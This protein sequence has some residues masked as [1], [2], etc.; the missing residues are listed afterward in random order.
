MAGAG[1]LQ[2]LRQMRFEALLDRHERGALSQVEAAEMQGITERTFRR[3]RD[4]RV[5]NTRCRL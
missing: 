4:R 3:W 1:V 5:S 2:G